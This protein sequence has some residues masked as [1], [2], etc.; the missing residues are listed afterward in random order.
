MLEMVE[1]PKL[2]EAGKK[3]IVTPNYLPFKC[4]AHSTSGTIIDILGIKGCRDRIENS[5]YFCPYYKS[6]KNSLCQERHL[7][8]YKY[9]YETN[10]SNTYYRCLLEMEQH[11]K[12]GR[13]IEIT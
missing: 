13:L 7:V 12:S 1:N 11:I 2:L 10:K 4:V 5:I 9:K 6:I 3:Y 8:E